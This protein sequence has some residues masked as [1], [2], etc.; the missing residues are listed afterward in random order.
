VATAAAHGGCT[1]AAGA[2][3][4]DIAPEVVATRMV[5]TRAEAISNKPLICQAAI[6]LSPQ[7]RA[8]AEVD[9]STR[10]DLPE[11]AANRVKAGLFRAD[12]R[13]MTTL[14]Q[15]FQSRFGRPLRRP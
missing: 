2:D 10:P 15:L 9:R 8:I 6:C 4:F 13:R 5:A 7:L 11:P 12:V 14:Y 1:A 3:C